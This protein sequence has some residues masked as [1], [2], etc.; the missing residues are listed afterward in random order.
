MPKQKKSTGGTPLPP[1]EEKRGVPA[2]KPLRRWILVVLTIV[3]LAVFLVH[4]EWLVVAMVNG[5]PIF[6]WEVTN[7]LM[8]RFGKQTLEGIISERLIADAAKR[9]GVAVSREE[10]D[11]KTSD[12]VAGL[13]GNVKLEDILKFQ[14]MTKR[15]FDS[16]IRLQL[17]VEKL[18]GKEIEITEED[19]DAYIATNRALLTATEPAALR[20]EARNRIRNEKVSE[21]IQPWFTQLKEK[22]NI[23]RFL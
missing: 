13:G 11:A 10:V 18:L 5:R 23:L 3:L 16:Q 19:V 12:I 15:E 14:G 7:T 22:A 6:R 17:T 2:K 1:P 20:Q 4:K 8:S 21:K 9:E